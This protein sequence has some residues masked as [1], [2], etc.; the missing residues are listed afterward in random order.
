MRGGRKKKEAREIVVGVVLLSPDR[1]GRER[2]QPTRGSAT[3]SHFTEARMAAKH[4]VDRL[5]CKTDFL[6]FFLTIFFMTRSLSRSSKK[7]ETTYH[8]TTIHT[9]CR[10]QCAVDG[11]RKAFGEKMT[12]VMSAHVDFVTA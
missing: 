6:F 7:P 4:G 11:E 12:F 3:Y 5:L 1:G 2:T 9:R 10:S 8:K